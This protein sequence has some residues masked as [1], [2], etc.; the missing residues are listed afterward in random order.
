MALRDSEIAT[1]RAKLASS[2][3]GVSALKEGYRVKLQELER[4]VAKLSAE[5]HEKDA[6]LLR[7]MQVETANSDHSVKS[8]LSGMWFCG[9]VT[10]SKGEKKPKK[11][12]LLVGSGVL[13]EFKIYS[14]KNID[15]C[16]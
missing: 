8:D 16:I 6:R 15:R 4:S 9:Y 13:I 2:Q 10:V 5:G 14:L 12:V 3:A 11:R 1:L 7:L